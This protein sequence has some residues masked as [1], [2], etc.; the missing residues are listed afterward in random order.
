[1][2]EQDLFCA[3]YAL[4]C[5]M[6]PTKNEMHMIIRTS[7]GKS[8]NP[9]HSEES[10]GFS[11][12][13][14][15][16]ESNWLPDDYKSTALPSELSRRKTV[17]HCV[18]RALQKGSKKVLNNKN[19]IIHYFIRVRVGFPDFFGGSGSEGVSL[20]ETTDSDSA[21]TG[22]GLPLVA[23]AAACATVGTA[24]GTAAGATAGEGASAG[25]CTS[26]AMPCPFSLA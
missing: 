17:L 20:V 2:A 10:C 26:N 6:H 19:K 8:K 13:C 24:V 9:H 12:W 4:D 5:D 25:S 22:A 7:S 16:P 1:L 14:R 23:G 18:L 11:D 3:N 21:V 15:L